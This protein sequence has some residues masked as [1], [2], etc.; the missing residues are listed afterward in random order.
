MFKVYFLFLMAGSLFS[1]LAAQSISI[2][3]LC[4]LA[5]NTTILQPHSCTEWL[6]CPS[7]IEASDMETG[8][9]VVGL[10]FNKNTGKCDYKEN[11]QCP[12]EISF[13]NRC[14]PATEGSFLVDENNCSGYIYCQNGGR[15]ENQFAPTI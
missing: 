13:K 8:S 14:S 10:Y 4:S 5:P 2:D 9:C 11:V 1:L 12:F 7:T 3:L 6:K 15:N